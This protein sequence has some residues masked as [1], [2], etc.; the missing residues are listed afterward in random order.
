MLL[1]VC[2]NIWLYIHIFTCVYESPNWCQNY[3]NTSL[4]F[5]GG[6]V[7]QSNTEFPDITRLSLELE[8]YA[9]TSH[10]HVAF[11]WYA[12]VWTPIMWQVHWS[13]SY[14]SSHM[15]LESL[16][17]WAMIWR[18][19]V[20]MTALFFWLQTALVIWCLLCFHLDFKIVF[21]FYEEWY[22]HFSCNFIESMGYF[23]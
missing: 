4:K 23:Q 15:P 21:C 20:V 11:M 7:S 13:L 22:G 3:L 2:K 8:L 5:W 14:L 10:I 17:M 19:I 16:W 12:D 1:Y 9:I 18:H 6:S